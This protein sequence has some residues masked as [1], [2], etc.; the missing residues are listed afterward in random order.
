MKRMF[1]AEVLILVQAN[2]CQSYAISDLHRI[3]HYH[4]GPEEVKMVLKEQERRKEKDAVAPRVVVIPCHED[5]QNNYI[6]VK[7]KVDRSKMNSIDFHEIRKRVRD[8]CNGDK[9]R[10][11]YKLDLGT[12][13]HNNSNRRDPKR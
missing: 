12:C 10:N 1:T 5:Y 3:L 13:G 7:N 2:H 6:T 4:L 11:I 9:N 8:K